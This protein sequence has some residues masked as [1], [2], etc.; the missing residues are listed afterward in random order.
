ML[1]C[2]IW[3]LAFLLLNSCSSSEQ[4]VKQL[5]QLTSKKD[6]LNSQTL[7]NYTIPTNNNDNSIIILQYGGLVNAGIDLSI[8]TPSSFEINDKKIKMIVP[9]AKINAIYPDLI[10]PTTDNNT[11]EKKLK[12]KTKNPEEIVKIIKENI[13]SISILQQTEQRA[14]IL[15]QQLLKNYGYNAISI[16]FSDN[17]TQKIP[18]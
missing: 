9:T 14:S 7:V 13:D 18:K 17:I 15:L 3:F 12:A 6:W 8:L 11:A 10:Q 16:R 1:R 5:M 4:K 2:F